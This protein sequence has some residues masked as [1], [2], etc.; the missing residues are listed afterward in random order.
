MAKQALIVDDSKTARQVLSSK[1]QMYGIKVE[2]RESAAAAIDYLYDNEPDAIFM[3]YEM[4]GMDGFQA[5]K[6][7]KSNPHTAVIPVMMYTSMAGG[8]AISQARALGAVGVLPKQLE[9]QDL[10]EVLHS[11][12]L[13]P[14]QESLVHGFRDDDFGRIS[15]ARPDNVLPMDSERRKASTAEQVSLPIE[16]FEESLSDIEGIKRLIRREHR[17]VE[18]HLQDRIDKHY[19]ELHE[20]IYELQ[21]LLDESGFQP[22]RFLLLSLLSILLL[23]GISIAYYLNTTGMKDNAGSAPVIAKLDEVLTKVSAQDERIDQLTQQ[24]VSG[25]A[26]DDASG[27][28]Q[29]PLA[30]IEWAANQGGGFEFAQIPFDDQRVL[31]LSGL[32][33]KLREAGFRG[34]VELRANYG[35]FCLSK[36]ESG[37]LRLADPSL[38]ISQCLFAVDQKSGDLQ[39]NEQSVAFAN[40]LNIEI[41]RSGG[42]IT[43]LLSS[44]G[45]GDPVMPYPGLYEVKTAGEWNRIAQRN[46]RIRVSLN[47]NQ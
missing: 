31:W 22:R 40:Y 14:E 25:S 4:P 33:E 1:L 29:L 7:I 34:T 13:L 28:Q 2:T 6:V 23:I 3:D 46:Q 42:E 12:H 44:S 10:E 16:S 19:G 24:M 15:L 18:G 26:L 17:Q 37:A 32:V 45:F 41:A 30:L 47:S 27:E 21:A 5:L 20:E 38:E 39:Q 11:L 8:L 35:N 43:I 9:P 36:D